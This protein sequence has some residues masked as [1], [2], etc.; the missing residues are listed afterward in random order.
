MF[1]YIEDILHY[2][3]DTIGVNDADKPILNSI[4]KQCKKG[5][6]LTDRQYELVKNKM[7]EQKHL[8]LD[9]K[10]ILED[11][12][13]PRLPIRQID[14]S[15]YI[16]IVN[17][18]D[19]YGNSPYESHKSSWSWIK[20]RFPFSKKDIATLEQ[21]VSKSVSAR[22]KRKEYH[23]VRGSHEHY[24]YLSAFNAYM[25]V[26]SFKN[27]NFDIVDELIE[28]HSKTKHIINNA[29]NYIPLVRD[30]GLI[31]LNDS[32]IEKIKKD[33]GNYIDNK[34]I[35]KDRAFRYG[36]VYDT[37]S[38]NAS[39]ASTI[40]MRD[41]TEILIDPNKHNINN[42][43]EAVIELDRFPLVVVLDEDK[44]CDQLLEIHQA[45][46]YTVPAELQ[47]VMFRV[48]SN[49]D[50]NKYLNE[51]V[52]INNL[53][54]WVDNNTKIVYIKK[55]KLPKALLTSGFCPIATLG[56][57]SMRNNAQVDSYINFNC[58]LIMYHDNQENL[59]G[60]YSRRYGFL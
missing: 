49:D 19:V 44:A 38:S 15:K 42:I 60:K 14:R 6:A 11:S 20:I 33:L 55:N 25:I 26:E 52:K 51:Y 57:T 2:Y 39:L 48:D 41:N 22:Q 12:F 35:Y 56:K 3:V 46:K 29:T 21:I 8:F 58:D 13:E 24:F 45:F 17:T 10:I 59:F 37:Y 30:N 5:I 7:L 47:S 23:H 53:N 36:Y 1:A 40:A 4:S 9:K 28:L 43:V 31:N 16:C 27:R 54:N 18:A 34:T 32:V 50:D